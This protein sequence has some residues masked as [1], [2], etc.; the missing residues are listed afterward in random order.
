MSSSIAFHVQTAYPTVYAFTVGLVWYR[1][2]VRLEAIVWFFF[3]LKNKHYI[4]C[5][6]WWRDFYEGR[7]GAWGGGGWRGK[8]AFPSSWKAKYITIHFI[9][10]KSL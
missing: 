7:A 9:L 1:L 2:T 8:N 6:A 5:L 4:L 3:N 10:C